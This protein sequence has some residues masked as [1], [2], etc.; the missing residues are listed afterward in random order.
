MGVEFLLLQV[1]NSARVLIYYAAILPGMK[2]KFMP[3]NEQTTAPLTFR[4]RLM[5]ME[6]FVATV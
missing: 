6:W 1:Y 2:V 3:L 5:E 4:E